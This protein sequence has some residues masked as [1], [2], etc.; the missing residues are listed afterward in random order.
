MNTSCLI[1]ISSVMMMDNISAADSLFSLQTTVQPA[2]L[3]RLLEIRSSATHFTLADIL[4]AQANSPTDTPSSTANTPAAAHTTQL[5]AGS[6]I[7]EDQRIAAHCSTLFGANVIN[8][9]APSAIRRIMALGGRT[10]EMTTA[11]EI[12]AAAALCVIKPAFNANDLAAYIHARAI[13][14]AVMSDDELAAA[15]ALYRV[16]PAFDKSSWDTYAQTAG[17]LYAMKP[18]FDSSDWSA[19][20]YATHSGM[21]I[22]NAPAL[23]TAVALLE[24]KAGFDANDLAVYTHM[25]A[26][27]GLNLNGQDA[28]HPLPVRAAIE[29]AVDLVGVDAVFAN[30][31]ANQLA[32]YT[33]AR[34]IGMP[35]KTATELD[36][37]VALHAVKPAFT[38]AELAAAKTLVESG[39]RAFT[40]E[41]LTAQI[42]KNQA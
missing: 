38:A 28:A 32:A 7:D 4:E 2:T 33:H 11:D 20:A 31:T 18:T 16:Y 14:I 12:N 19:Y 3:R 36:L 25:R 6:G 34:A 42:Q 9:D 17:A 22:A 27:G 23:A 37:A 8:I 21:V 15:A 10:I 29:M 41:D 39:N 24:L 5:L 30:F 13:G 40:Y 35:I 26:A 1:A